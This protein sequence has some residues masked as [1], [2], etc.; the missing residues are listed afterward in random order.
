VVSVGVGT[1]GS[2]LDQA[3]ARS[4]VDAA[5]GA[6]IR[7]SHRPSYG[8]G[9]AGLPGP[10]LAGR[11]GRAVIATKFGWG[12][13]RD[14]HSEARGRPEYVREAID[15]SLRRLGVDY[16]DLYQYHRPDGVTSVA[17]T[18]GAMDELVSTG[19]VR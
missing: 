8:D 1:F 4:V 10:A 12:R 3:A 16:V 9:E 17:E 11:R 7:C 13:G 19:K 14:D 2:R 6:G 15:G 5:L 18:L